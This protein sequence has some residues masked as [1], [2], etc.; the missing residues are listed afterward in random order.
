MHAMLPETGY[1]MHVARESVQSGD[2]EWAFP[3]RRLPESGSQVW[4]TQQRIP[5][6]SGM[7]ILES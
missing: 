6:G 7:D 1:E 4:A 2:C 3:Q 5:S